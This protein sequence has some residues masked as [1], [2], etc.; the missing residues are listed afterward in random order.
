[1]LHDVTRCPRCSTPIV[2]KPEIICA[3]CGHHYPRL[4][5]IPILLRDPET[6]LQ[7]CRA[8]L[9]LLEQRTDRTV[10]SIQQQL[11]AS[12]VLETTKVRCRAMIQAVREQAHEIR[13][14]LEPV[15]GA[16]DVAASGEVPAPLQ[17]I[18]YLYRDWGWPSNPDGENER[19]LAM[20]DRVLAKQSLGRTL[21]LGAGACRLAYDLHRRD[22]TAETVV[23]D[24]EPF[25]FTCA[26][27]IVRGGSLTIHEANAEVQETEHASTAWKLRAQ[28]GPIAEDR[29]QF[30]IADGLEPPFDPEAFD[31]IVTPWFI[32]VVPSDLRDVIST[33]HRLLKPGGSWIDVGPLIYRPG[34]PIA[35]R[36]S[37]EE[38]FDLAARAGF[39]IDSWRSESMPYLVSKLNGRGKVEWILAFAATKIEA[40]S[41]DKPAAWL[42]FRHLPIPTFAAQSMFSS[43]DP[44]IQMVVPAI[45]GRRTLDDIAKLVA[46]QASETGLTMSQFR[47]IVRRCL[48]E[49]HPGCAR[50]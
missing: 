2:L 20:V 45:D 44:A 42:L 4:G 49:F 37:R 31:T 50:K 17:Y 25:L 39:R 35:H 28:N 16:P 27:T 38:L 32:D 8:Q 13:A 24:I 46:A 43:N 34:V 12:D 29:F 33:V 6:Y 36:F 5:D 26:H 7:S 22:A 30:I 18:H 15:T 11:Q 1:M 40:V 3:G 14:I 10:Q 23:L 41:E 9:G 48:A 47:E 21:V 19:V